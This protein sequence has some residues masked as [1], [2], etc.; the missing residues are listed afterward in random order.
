M[1][2]KKDINTRLIETI[3]KYMSNNEN[4]ISRLEGILHIGQQSIYRRLRGE[5]PF[6]FEEVMKIAL[7][8]SFS[9]DEIIG[10]H[11]HK[12]T[13]LDMESFL[14]EEL[15]IIDLYN[16]FTTK[17][18]DKMR[19]VANGSDTLLVSSRNK[20]PLS[21]LLR[22]E[23]LT[24]F[25]YLKVRHLQDPQSSNLQFSK[26]TLDINNKALM[27]QYINNY[28][29]IN[30]IELIIDDNTLLSMI[31]EITY[32]YKRRLITESELL[33]LQSELFELINFI[34]KQM[35][36]GKNDIGT[37]I[38]CYLS[39]FNIET[40]YSY[41]QYNDQKIVKFWAYAEIPMTITDPRICDMQKEWLDSL[42]KYSTLITGSNEIQRVR[43]LDRQKEYIDNIGKDIVLAH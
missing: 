12:G 22:Y 17:M 14:K 23:S 3:R 35:A 15:D 16:D 8:L 41:L 11:H 36:E 9:L 32:F 40:N 39:T 21:L 27:K 6:T 34:E 31:K 20:I 4:I 37:R 29:R 43:Y 25:R 30:N 18:V 42:K 7:N 24:R 13:F 10:K 1:K 28:R 5:I 2:E 26:V 38:T 33:V 19:E